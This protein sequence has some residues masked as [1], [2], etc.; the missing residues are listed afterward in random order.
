M[1]QESLIK[2]LTPVLALSDE[3]SMSTLQSGAINKV[4]RLHDGDRTFAVKWVGDDVFSGI[5]RLHQ[6]VL[7]EQLA[8]RH[9]APEPLWLSDDGR[10]WVEEW[11]EPNLSISQDNRDKVQVLANILSTIHRQPITAQPLELTRRW[12]HYIESAGLASVDPLVHEAHALHESLHLDFNDDDVLTLCHNDLSWGH[13][14]NVSGPV[15]VDWEYGAMGNRYFDLASC[16]AVNEFS[17]AES[18]MLCQHYAQA[19]EIPS[20]VVFQHYKL[21]TQVVKVTNRLWQAALGK[22]RGKAIEPPVVM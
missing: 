9:I 20:E 12:D 17:E 22:S 5:N 13:I 21:Q 2:L 4:Y 1:Q 7:Q 19:S 3:A 10:L 6:F 18:S 15:I 16:C 8:H 11:V 14:L